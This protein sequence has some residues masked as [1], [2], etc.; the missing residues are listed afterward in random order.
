MA[1][2]EVFREANPRITFHDDCYI[3]RTPEELERTRQNIY[4]INMRMGREIE[5][6]RRER[7]A[8]QAVQTD[9]AG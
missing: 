2:V 6:K 9:N 3:N 8:Q 5:R 7:E 1:L 4:N